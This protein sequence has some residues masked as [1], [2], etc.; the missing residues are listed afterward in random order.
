M[1]GETIISVAYGV[2]VLPKDDPYITTAEKG[3]HTLVSAA[4]PGAFLV[5]T[6]PWLKHVPDW[7]PFAGFKRKAKEWRKLAMSMIEK[8]FEA[9]KQKIVGSAVTYQL[10]DYHCYYLAGTRRYHALILIVTINFELSG[11]S[12][13]PAL[14]R[15][16]PRI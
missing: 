2:N 14:T 4:V 3:V 5:D 13:Q 11:I 1:A 9:G 15:Y 8:P 16:I 12:V 6:F 7:M 10:T